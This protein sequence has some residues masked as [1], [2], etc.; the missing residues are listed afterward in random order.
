VALLAARSSKLRGIG[1]ELAASGLIVLADKGYA[2]AG[3]HAQ[4]PTG[5]GANR[6]PR[7]REAP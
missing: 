4:I 6:P 7:R 3:E 5:A 1:R 2:G